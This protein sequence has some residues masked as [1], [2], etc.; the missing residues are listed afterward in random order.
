MP[1]V[2]VN[3]NVRIRDEGTQP[4]VVFSDEEQSMGLLVDEIVDIVDDPLAIEITSDRP[5]VLGSAV[6][7]GLATEVID[8]SHFLPLAFGRHYGHAERRTVQRKVLLVDDQAFFRNL[9]SPIISAAGYAVTVA[10]GAAEAL[11]LI[12]NGERFD[13]IMSD[14]DMPDMSGFELAQVLRDDPLTAGVPVIGLTPV[15]SLDMARCARQ[16]GARDCVAKFDRNNL[17]A[18][19]EMSRGAVGQAA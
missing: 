5:G 18:A 4:L 2:P 1:L 17:I 7:K 3:E 15:D 6:I 16:F 9:L 14:L 11:D 8:I 19:L 10:A 12:K 13:V